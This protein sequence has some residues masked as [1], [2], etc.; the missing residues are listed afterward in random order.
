MW[1]WQAGIVVDFVD[2]LP[3]RQRDATPEEREEAR[4]EL[5]RK[6]DRGEA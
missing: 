5:F 3:V 1:I 2:G 6:S 4:D